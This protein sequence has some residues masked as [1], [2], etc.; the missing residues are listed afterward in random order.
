MDM[1][2]QQSEQR[3]RRDQIRATAGHRDFNLL[4]VALRLDVHVVQGLGVG[5]R[6]D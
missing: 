6:R 1:P 3:G 4:G 2:R 5:R